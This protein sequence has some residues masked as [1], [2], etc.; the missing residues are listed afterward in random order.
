VALACGSQAGGSAPAAAG[1]AGAAGASQDAGPEAGK[2][3]TDAAGEEPVTCSETGP[4]DLDGLFAIFVRLSFTFGSHPGGA[5]TVCPVDQAGEG[6]FLALLRVTHTPGS[7][8]VASLEAVVCSLALPV[9]S[10]V[11][12]E[13]DAA[14]KNLVYAGLQFPQKLI[15]ALP[16]TPVATTTAKLGG[17]S[18]GSALHPGRLTFILGTRKLGAA[19]PAWDSSRPGCGMNDTAAG[20]GP[21]CEKACVTDCDGLVDDDKDGW[22]AVT[23][24]VCGYTDDDKKQKVACNA[25]EPSTA[26]A[27]IQGRAALDLQVDPLFSGVAQSSCE[28]S[29]GIDSKF[30]Y[31]VVGADLYLANTP[32]SV[33]ASYSSLPQ[34]W[35][36]LD[37]SRFRALRIDGKHG[38][39]DW[40]PS[41]AD[42]VG[43]CKTVIARQNELK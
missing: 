24:H 26:G 38:A 12:G 28:I 5:V 33:T 35:V 2:A 39:R 1:A 30:T 32:V 42:L 41:W 8:S 4:L 15:E 23:V 3:G 7:T 14:P 22:P 18:P 34:Y 37:A 36:D 20:R 17:T 19:M 27:T 43:T 11:V 25:E 10:A 9:I 6:N 31:N 16:A 21:T 29:G 40:S 13:C